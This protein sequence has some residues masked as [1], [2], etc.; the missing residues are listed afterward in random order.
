MIAKVV[1][2][3]DKECKRGTI[4]IVLVREGEP[5]VLKSSSSMII[6]IEKRIRDNALGEETWMP[7]SELLASWVT[8]LI[9]EFIYNQE[10]R[11]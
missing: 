9:L 10:K 5:T 11:R 3:S 7:D 8:A 1:W 4:R 6:R 2:Q